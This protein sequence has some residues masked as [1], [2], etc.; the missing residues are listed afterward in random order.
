MD[1]D[2]SP[3]LLYAILAVI[4]AYC[5]SLCVRSN[6]L[7]WGGYP[8]P[9]GPLLRYAFLGKQPERA[10]HAWAQKYGPLFSL[11]VGDQLFM[12][13]SDPQVAHDLLVKNGRIFSSRKVYFIKTQTIFRG[14]AITST[15]YGDTWQVETLSNLRYATI[16]TNGYQA[17]ASQDCPAAPHSQSS[18]C[19]HA[20]P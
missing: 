2:S 12:V 19:T 20:E 13:I 6:I 15:P 16:Q 5:V 4:I 9:P 3:K 8:I 18:E 14:R 7:N 10:F 11:F 1:Q 17:K